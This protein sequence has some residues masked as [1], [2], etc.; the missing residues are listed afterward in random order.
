MN[1]K[2][3]STM[4]QSSEYEHLPTMPQPRQCEH[5]PTM[6]QPRQC[7]HVPTMPQE[8]NRISSNKTLILDYDIE[9]FGEKGGNFIIISSDVISNSSGES[10]I[11]KCYRRTDRTISYVAR[12]LT[13]ITPSSKA[14]N[15]IARNKIIPAINE[16]LNCIHSAGFVHRDIK[17][18]NLYYYNGKVVVGDFGI[19][20]ELKDGEIASDRNKMGILG[21]YALNL[22]C[23]QHL[24]H[25]II[26]LLDKLYGRFTV[27]E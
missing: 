27:D 12:I 21:Y 2:H 11:Y 15:R 24:K 20:C 8:N 19:S 13:S 9:F 3:I 26:T 22:P 10:Q 18:D 1:N 7:E 23:K 17:P 6:P 5:L 16:A 4:P 25:L 14:E